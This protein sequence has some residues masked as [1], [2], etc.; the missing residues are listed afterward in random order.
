[1]KVFACLFVAFV[2]LQSFGF[3][4]A[5]AEFVDEQTMM[6][7]N[8][9][10]A[11]LS[12]WRE[13]NLSCETFGTLLVLYKRNIITRGEYAS[14]LMALSRNNAIC[15]VVYRNKTYDILRDLKISQT[16]IRAVLSREDLRYFYSNLLYN[17]PESA[18]IGALQDYLLAQ[19][20]RWHSPRNLLELV[21]GK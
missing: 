5:V 21:F 7:P 11:D 15:D 20:E 4:K 16:A 17:I 6:R 1:M 14:M 13:R 10:Y 18:R 8:Y 9:Y 12:Q 3:S 19:H 2:C